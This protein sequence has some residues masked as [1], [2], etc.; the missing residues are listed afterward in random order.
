MVFIK[1]LLA[2]NSLLNSIVCV[3]VKKSKTNILDAKLV[4][5]VISQN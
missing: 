2:K 1:F 3:R 5:I 4:K